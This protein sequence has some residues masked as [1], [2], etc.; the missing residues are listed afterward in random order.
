MHVSFLLPSLCPV[1]LPDTVS[2]NLQLIPGFCSAIGSGSF[3]LKG[4]E[5]DLPAWQQ[6]LLYQI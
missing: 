2:L 4:F 5:I 1:V 3:V 6:L